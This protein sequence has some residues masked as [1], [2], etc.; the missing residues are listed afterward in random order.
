MEELLSEH[1][2][3]TWE[4]C[5]S[6]QPGSKAD[7]EKCWSDWGRR[8]HSKQPNVVRGKWIRLDD[9]TEKCSVCGFSWGAEP[10]DSTNYCPYCGAKMDG[11]CQEGDGHE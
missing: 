11:A 8:T 10:E 5:S 1:A 9:W 7:C 6:C 2:S 4:N 3:L